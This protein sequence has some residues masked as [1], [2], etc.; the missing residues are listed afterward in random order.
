MSCMS[1]DYGLKHGRAWDMPVS[2]GYIKM[3]GTSMSTPVV[4]GAVALLLEKHPRLQ[5][6]DVKYL[7]KKSAVNLYYPKN[8]Q[9]WGA[10]DIEALLKYGG[11][12]ERQLYGDF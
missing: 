12:Y 2:A 1:L 9:G 11:Q 8:Q 10:L 4:A 6:N 7:L 5:P 3:S